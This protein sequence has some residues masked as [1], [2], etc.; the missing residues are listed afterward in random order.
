MAIASEQGNC[1][2]GPYLQPTA[3]SAF[4]TDVTGSFGAHLHMLFASQLTYIARVVYY[5]DEIKVNNK[6]E[7]PLTPC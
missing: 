3:L 2:A 6:A 7:Q 4:V 1:I 5:V